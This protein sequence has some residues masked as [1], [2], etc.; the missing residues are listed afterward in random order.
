MSTTSTSEPFRFSVDTVGGANASMHGGSSFG[1]NDEGLMRE[2]RNELRRL[3]AEISSLCHS[4]IASDRF[5]PKFLN[6]VGSAMAADAG[7]IWRKQQS[8][9]TPQARCGSIDPR[10]LE[11]TGGV[12]HQHMIQEIGDSGGP[13]AVPPGADWDS[14]EPGNPTDLLATVVPVPVDPD[15]PVEWLVELFLPVGG[16]PAT[17]RGY[18]RFIAQMADLAADYMRSERLREA[19]HAA[20]FSQRAAALIADLQCATESPELHRSLVDGVRQFACA[21]RVS[22]ASRNGSRFK[23]L[24]VSGVAA[25]DP[26][27]IALR[28]IAVVA[29]EVSSSVGLTAAVDEPANTNASANTDESA[30]TVDDSP[31]EPYDSNE[32]SGDLAL[33]GVVVLDR[34][35]D[36]RLVV[37]D[38]HPTHVTALEVR[39][40]QTLARQLGGILAQAERWHTSGF[41]GQLRHGRLRH[42]RLGQAALLRRSLAPLGM[43]ATLVI[44]G[45]I[46]I[47]LVITA[48]GNI[49]PTSTQVVYAPR[50]AVVTRLLVT[51]GQMVRQGDP[52]LQLVDRDLD[53]QIENMASRLSILDERT[54]SLEDKQ[55]Q[56]DG[57]DGRLLENLALEQR[58]IEEE[59]RGLIAQIDICKRNQTSLLLTSKVAGRVDAWQIQ[60]SLIDRPVGRG[61]PLLKVVPENQQWEVQAR[62]P[63]DR[64]D[65]LLAL[66]DQQTEANQ[67][68]EARL[69]LSAFPD[70]QVNAEL[71]EIGPVAPTQGPA[72]ASPAAMATFAIASD[73]LPIQQ[74]GAP[75]EIGIDCGKRPLGY[76]L[77]LDLI[78]MTA[79]TLRLYW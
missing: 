7:I 39:L 36:W 18:L 73:D 13:V 64:L 38:L 42:G 63:Q 24:A 62:I 27:S 52:L 28:T 14:E 56:A 71:T 21:E 41:L 54:K 16:G 74:A 23:V 17:Q 26:H 4:R 55:T 68:V 32:Q 25:M 20:D 57:S 8:K 65:L 44:A 76:V 2:T 50:D 11:T 5:W 69:V 51:H 31:T 77:G 10:L 37:E 70:H 79:R 58:S 47:P 66:R 9:W 67:P 48:T 60:Q 15:E 61:H 19:V 1:A 45:L 53:Q 6:L 75:V 33:R 12:C 72:F 40:W 49:Q 43:A 59:A 22:L 78:R 29:G 3:V 34:A 30:N 46:P 35:G